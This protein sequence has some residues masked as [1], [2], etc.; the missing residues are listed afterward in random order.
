[1]Q[2]VAGLFMDSVVTLAEKSL[3][4]PHY[5]I[6]TLQ[7][8]EPAADTVDFLSVFHTVGVSDSLGVGG[9]DSLEHSQAEVD[10]VEFLEK[11]PFLDFRRDSVTAVVQSSPES[12]ILGSPMPLRPQNNSVMVLLLLL[13]FFSFMYVLRLPQ[14]F[15]AIA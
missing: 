5:K 3:E 4:S 13:G 2:S 12:G 9:V 8:E 7:V 10:S 14:Y 1:M 15:A 11:F 6:P